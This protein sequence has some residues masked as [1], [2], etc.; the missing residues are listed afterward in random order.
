[1]DGV[2][3][4]GGMHGFGPIPYEANQEPFHDEWERRVWGLM[5]ATTPPEDGTLDGVR[6]NL[7]NMPPHLYLSYEYYERWLYH[8]TTTVIASGAVTLEEVLSGSAAPDACA[9]TDAA[10]PESVDPYVVTPYQREIDDPPKFS[11]GDKVRTSNLHPRGHTRLPRY[12]RDKVGEISLHHGAH[13]LPD[14][15]AHGHG[16]CPTHL[17]CVT[18]AAQ[19]LWGPQ[20]GARDSTA[21]DVWECHLELA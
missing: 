4:M 3:D 7:E 21:L 12:A 10:G 16:E 5:F 6:H 19:E 20:A 13:V 17:Y 14:T 1:M 9:R 2:H 15:N 8:L 11:I 18:F